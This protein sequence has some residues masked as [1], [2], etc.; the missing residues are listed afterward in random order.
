[1]YIS[2]TKLM[3]TGILVASLIVIVTAYSQKNLSEGEQPYTPS[4]LDW[5][6]VKLN[7]LYPYQN[8][9]V[10]GFYISYHPDP[11]HENTIKILCTYF[12]DRA[13]RNLMNVSI[14]GARDLAMHHAK[15]YGWD[16]WIKIKESIKPSQQ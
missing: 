14:Q 16:S 8:L 12:Q 7:S 4:R 11:D 6:T 3:L 9:S 10:V 5:L 2:K 15:N 13:D 1:M